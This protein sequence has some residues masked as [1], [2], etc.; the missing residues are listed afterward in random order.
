MLEVIAI[1]LLGLAV[2]SFLNVLIDRLPRDESPFRGRSYCESCKKP[3]LWYDLIPVVSILFLKGKCRYCR[4][5]ISWYYPI[6]ELTTGIMFVAVTIFV[7]N[8]FQFSIFN[9]QSNLNFQLSQTSTIAYY[10]F[11]IS[12]LIVVFF[13]DL[14]YGI[15]PD[16]VVYPSILAAI[17]YL[18]INH[19]SLIINHLLAAFGAFLFFLALY[20]LTKG[21]GM[22]FGDVKLVFLLGLVLGFPKIIVAFYIAFLTG[23]IIG[24]I[25]IL[26]GKK[27]LGGTTIPFGPFLVAGAFIALFVDLHYWSFLLPW[28]FWRF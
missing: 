27:K 4:S 22:G 16:K 10:L 7:L 13:V 12:S 28:L 18:F 9:F 6:V 17:V 19:Q 26:W 25:L 21:K 2:G 3:L 1:F 24:I 14:K 8:N 20:L 23:A 11:I 15:I 5:P